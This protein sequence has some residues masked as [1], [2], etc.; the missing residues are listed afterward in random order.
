[1]KQ[2]MEIKDYDTL[3]DKQKRNLQLLWIPKEGDFVLNS[4]TSDGK[5]LVFANYTHQPFD[6]KPDW[7]LLVTLEDKRS[8]LY[9]MFN[10]LQMIELMNE[11]K[12]SDKLKEIDWLEFDTLFEQVFLIFKDFLNRDY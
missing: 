7:K 12:Y 10:V 6:D 9:P 8:H 1:M 4:W 11:H 5:G 3:N 2:R